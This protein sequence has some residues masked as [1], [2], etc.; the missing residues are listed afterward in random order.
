M[1]S[2]KSFT[3]I[4]LLVVI[5]IIAILASMLLPALNK[6]RDKAS[7]I[8][9]A[10]A[11][12]Q[13]GTALSMYT[14]DYDGFI[15][16]AYRSDGWFWYYV[17]SSMSNYISRPNAA[18][19]SSSIWVCPQAALKCDNSDGSIITYSRFCN[20]DYSSGTNAAYPI[21]R[22]KNTSQ[23]IIINEGGKYWGRRAALGAAGLSY[24]VGRREERGFFHSGNGVMNCTFADGH[25]KG[26]RS[27]EMT[28]EMTD[29]SPL[30]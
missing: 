21:K 9:C 2:S 20:S 8:S 16:A 25:V 12:K 14:S 23:I 3:L 5:A 26:I 1:K 4:E 10:S 17:L 27:K 18:P 13:I 7:I 15:P 19:H 22:I 6:A 11:E 29:V 28:K 24:D 30:L